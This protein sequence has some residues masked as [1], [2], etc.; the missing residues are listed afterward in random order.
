MYILGNDLF[1][2]LFEKITK[3]IIRVLNIRKSKCLKVKHVNVDHLKI[4]SYFI[5]FS[6][7]FLNRQR[8]NKRF[9][10]N[11]VRFIT[12]FVILLDINVTCSIQLFFIIFSSVHQILFFSIV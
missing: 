8:P 12:L 2:Y 4:I 9:I 10:C 11:I 1:Y 6:Q 5:Q 3:N 7:K